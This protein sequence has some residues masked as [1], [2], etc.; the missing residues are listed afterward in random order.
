VGSDK[1]ATD[2]WRLNNGQ[3]GIR[4]SLNNPR[5]HSEE[6]QR[7]GEQRRTSFLQRFGS[8]QASMKT[9]AQIKNYDTER[10]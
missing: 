8:A 5:D 9:I 10:P 2:L 6:V 4:I 3:L 7:Y 1:A